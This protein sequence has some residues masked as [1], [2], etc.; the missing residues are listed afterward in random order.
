MRIPKVLIS[1]PGIYSTSGRGTGGCLATNGSDYFV[2]DHLDSTGLFLHGDAVYRFIRSLNL[3]VKYQPDGATV[4]MHLPEVRDGHDLRVTTSGFQIVSTSSNRILEYAWDRR[5]LHERAFGGTEDGWHINSLL[6]HE[7][8]IFF[9]AF[10][11]FSRERG[12]DQSGSSGYGFVRNLQTGIDLWKGLNKPHHPRA[13][14]NGYL[15]C[16]SGNQTL[17]YKSQLDSVPTSLDCGGFTR[18]LLIQKDSFLVGVSADR[19]ASSAKP[20]AR[21]IHG[22]LPD[23][24]ILDEILLPFPEI[25]DVIPCPEWLWSG[26][27]R[28]EVSRFS[29]PCFPLDSV[30]YLQGEYQN[31]SQ[32]LKDV[33]NKLSVIQGNRVVQGYFKLRHWVRKS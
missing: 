23:M 18:G 32:S 19:K 15:V 1:S 14:K 27:E 28:G 24:S 31:L 16:D 20:Q 5:I 26:L 7:G 29:T 3:L 10:G 17:L 8:Q 4:V 30:E 25:Y 22:Q 11:E 12:W 21:I 9:S 13:Y 33:Q 2:L 6:E